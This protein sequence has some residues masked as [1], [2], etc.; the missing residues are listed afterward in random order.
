MHQGKL[1]IGE[2]Q[3]DPSTNSLAS[4]S[5][6]RQLETRAVDVLVYLAEHAPRTVSGD[7]LLDRFWQGRI[8][9]SSTVHRMISKIRRALGDA[10]SEPRYIETVPKRGYR[11]IAEI[12]AQR[13]A[14]SARSPSGATTIY[15]AVP[16]VNAAL[17]EE[18]EFLSMGPVRLKRGQSRIGREDD[19]DLVFADNSISKH[20]ARIYL[21][22]AWTIEDLGSTNG[23]CVNGDYVEKRRLQNGDRI[24]LG[25][26]V[27]RFELS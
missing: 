24:Q 8:V 9:E 15:H 3:V 25:Q 5:E 20:H 23:V 11:V 4:Q 19:N 6:T 2:W 16:G 13:E 1:R 22:N 18:T 17:V 27:F 10:P 21:D 12:E 26:V 7:E 14:S